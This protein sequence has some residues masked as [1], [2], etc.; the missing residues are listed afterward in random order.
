MLAAPDVLPESCFW[1]PFQMCFLAFHN[2][3]EI[4]A[5]FPQ[6]HSVYT[7]YSMLSGNCAYVGCPSTYIHVSENNPSQRQDGKMGVGDPT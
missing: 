6:Q 1:Y 3:K 2:I 7:F 5:P 4:I